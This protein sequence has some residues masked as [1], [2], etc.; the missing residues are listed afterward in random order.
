MN[1]W[2]FFRVGSNEDLLFLLLPLFLSDLC[3]LPV[4]WL[5]HSIVMTLMMDYK[6]HCRYWNNLKFMRFTTCGLRDP[7]EVAELQNHASENPS[8]HLSLLNQWI[9]KVQ[10]LA[11]GKIII[12]F[13][14]SKRRA[15]KHSIRVI[16]LL[17]CSLT[18][19]SALCE[20]LNIYYC[21]TFRLHSNLTR[22]ALLSL[23]F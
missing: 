16:E 8:I 6:T 19:L 2:E 21:I 23:L 4:L 15:S 5:F 7:W 14:S 1:Q 12:L 9:L 22:P 3:A 20:A 17:I 13:D 18:R 11:C 10:L